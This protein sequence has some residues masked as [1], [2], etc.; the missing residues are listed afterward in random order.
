M[1]INNSISCNAFGLETK[2]RELETR[3]PNIFQVTIHFDLLWSE[4]LID[5][6]V[7]KG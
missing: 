6:F 4:A 1:P 7:A 3:E 5:S 2:M